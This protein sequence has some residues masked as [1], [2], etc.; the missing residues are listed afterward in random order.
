MRTRIS[1]FALLLCLAHAAAM[2]QVPDTVRISMDN[3]GIPTSPG[4][5]LLDESPSVIDHPSSPKA[6]VAAIYNNYRQAGG[7]PSSY[8]VEFTPFWFFRHPKMTAFRYMGYDQPT[9]KQLPF[10]HIKKASL[11]LAYVSQPDEASTADISSIAFGIRTTLFSIRSKENIA[12]LQA[13]N[14]QVVMKLRDLN[15][16]I[17]ELDPL[18]PDYHQ[19][20]QQII[21]H[22]EEDPGLLQAEE[23][24]RMQME[25]KPLL[26]VD[27]AF[28]YSMFFL[29]NTFSDRHF[30]R[31]GIW[32]VANYSQPL[33]KDPVTVNYLSLSAILR[34]L[35]D[36]TE[37]ESPGNYGV[38][39]HVDF[40]AKAR[41]ELNKLSL[42]VEYVR[43]E[44]NE[45]AEGSFRAVGMIDYR[46]SPSFALNASF[47]RNFG[48]EQNLITLF[49]LSFGLNSGNEEAIVKD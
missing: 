40:G 30:G 33:G 48:Q 20:V 14:E 43:R 17:I 22:Y 26:A 36:G 4:F 9:G 31:L 37:P 8:G 15:R 35:R 5:I 16:R 44:G 7:F 45:P 46:L 3:P 42:A 11:S 2:A 38:S 29:D 24:L 27:A 1:A 18:A 47:G 28:A 10:S 19:K 32:A 13:A 25:V 41:L 6:F 12:A 34:Y 23:G 21:D 49:G 39:N